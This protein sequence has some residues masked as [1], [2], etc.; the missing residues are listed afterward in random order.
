MTLFEAASLQ[1]VGVTAID[2]PTPFASFEDYWQ[3]FAGGQGPAPAYA[4]ALDAT[5]QGSSRRSGQVSGAARRPNPT[6]ACIRARV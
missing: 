6:E 4:M 5:P 3:P 2:I 1:R